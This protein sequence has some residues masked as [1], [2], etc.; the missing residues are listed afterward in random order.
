MPPTVA[1]PPLTL[2]EPVTDFLHG[3]EVVDPY[4]WLEDQ[5]SPRTRSWLGAQE[6][7]TRAY[8]DSLPGRA[9]IRQRVG[10][11][12]CSPSVAEPWN[13]GDRY[14]FL[15]RTENREQP[16]IVVR[17]RLFGQETILVDPALRASSDT[18]AVAIAAIS[19]DGRFLAYAVREGGTDHSALEILDLERSVVLADGLP[20]GFCTG[21]A[22]AL[23]GSGF[24][25]SHREVDDPRPNYR[26]TFWHRFG[27][28]RSQDQ[29]VF[30]AGEEPNL[31]LGILASLE[32]KLLA[33]VVFSAGRHPVTSVYLHRMEPDAYP[34]PLLHGIEGCFAPFFVRGQLF[35]YTDQGA[36]N[37]RIVRIDMSNP[38]PEQWRDM[39]FPSLTDASSSLRLPA[40]TSS[41]P[42]SIVSQL[43][44]RC[45]T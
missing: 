1:A 37:C 13:V 6:A 20:E 27:T 34:K 44:S 32:A 11:L 30:I 7:Y 45:S 2:V 42:V 40:T 9:R 3:V 21:F 25:Y 16:T 26:A 33:Y 19:Q 15:K 4:R 36:K 12:L 39:E 14:F 17:D 5:D 8:F 28:N 10:E 43:K 31:F 23:D 18:V 22:F 38:N 35:A 29:Q 24:Y 41:S